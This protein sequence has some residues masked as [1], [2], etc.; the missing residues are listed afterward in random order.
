[1]GQAMP[2]LGLRRP[3]GPK[4]RATKHHGAL[5]GPGPRFCEVPHRRDKG[6]SRPGGLIRRSGRDVAQAAAVGDHLLLHEVAEG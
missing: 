6:R 1:V 4:L 2:A 5:R 3:C